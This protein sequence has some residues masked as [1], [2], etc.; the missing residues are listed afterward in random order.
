MIVFCTFHNI[1]FHILQLFSC[2]YKKK[3]KNKPYIFNFRRIL[4]ECYH[5]VCI[6]NVSTRTQKRESFDSSRVMLHSQLVQ[7]IS[8]SGSL[9]PALI[10]NKN[11]LEMSEQWKKKH[12]CFYF[13]DLFYSKVLFQCTNLHSEIIKTLKKGSKYSTFLKAFCLRYKCQQIDQ[14]RYKSFF[15]CYHSF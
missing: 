2:D 6:H 12:C 8:K 11:K 5:I 13:P 10:L 7:I 9:M 15:F 4:L 14:K 1:F 3:K